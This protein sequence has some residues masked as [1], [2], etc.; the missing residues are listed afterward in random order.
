MF[1]ADEETYALFYYNGHAVG[2]SEDIYLAT[3]ESSLDEHDPTPLYQVTF[4]PFYIFVLMSYST[5]HSNDPIHYLPG[6][7]YHFFI[8]LPCH[9]K[10]LSH[11]MEGVCCYAYLES[12]WKMQ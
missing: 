5:C 7:I 6:Y 4:S 2:H 10:G 1:D 3:V 9:L 8:Y 11:K 12:S